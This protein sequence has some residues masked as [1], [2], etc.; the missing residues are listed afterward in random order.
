MQVKINENFVE[1]EDGVAIT[2]LKERFYPDADVIIYNGHI[3]NCDLVVNDG[4]IVVFI[5]KGKIPSQN[6]LETLMLS[7]HTPGVHDKLKKG[8][9]AIAGLGGLGS[10][11]AVSLARMGIGYLKLIDYDVVEPS[12]LNRQQYFINQIGMLKTEALKQNLMNINPYIHYI[13]LNEFI[14]KENIKEIFEDVDIIIEAFDKAEYKSMLVSCASKNFP[15]KKIIAASGVAG[16][17]D[18]FKMKVTKLSKNIY[19]VGDLS[20]EARPGQGLMATR[21]AVAANIQANLAV[22]IILEES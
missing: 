9:V 16:L 8:R 11:I 21:V 6:E 7:R 1:V 22:N 18:P 20:S 2:L 3:V 19:V 5:K 14:T 15:D 13:F 17:G 4:D 10:N 12:N